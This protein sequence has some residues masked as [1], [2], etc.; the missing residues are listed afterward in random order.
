MNTHTMPPSTPL[1][2]EDSLPSISPFNPANDVDLQGR[3]DESL[4]E[5]PA[6]TREMPDT[7]RAHAYCAYGVI[8]LIV[9]WFILGIPCGLLAAHWGQ[10]AIDHGARGFGA[11]VR[12][13]GWIEVALSVI[14][15]VLILNE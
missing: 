10:A 8:A 7:D 9:G 14:G 12:V 15:I 1:A 5:V 6:V 13:C 2:A 11:F 3:A 4:P